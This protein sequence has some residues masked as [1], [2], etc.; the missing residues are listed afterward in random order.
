MFAMNSLICARTGPVELQAVRPAGAEER[1]GRLRLPLFASFE[2]PFQFLEAR[3]SIRSRQSGVVESAIKTN[4]RVQVVE[5]NLKRLH[6]RTANKPS[7]ASPPSGAPH[8]DRTFPRR[9]YRR[10]TTQCSYTSQSSE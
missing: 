2:A 10:S 6:W 1:P 8:T 3:L 5:T 4:Q 7:R 9:R